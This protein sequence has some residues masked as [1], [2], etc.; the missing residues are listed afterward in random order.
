MANP[1]LA[2]EILNKYNDS[3]EQGRS[4]LIQATW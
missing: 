1:Q 2:S 3:A 4:M